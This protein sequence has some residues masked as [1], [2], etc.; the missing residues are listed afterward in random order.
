MKVLSSILFVILLPLVSV[1]HAASLA[2]SS[3]PEGAMAYIISPANGEIVDKSVTIKFGLKGMGVSPAGIDKEGTGHHHLLVDGKMLPAL[4]KPMGTE[5]MHFGGGQTEK[6]LE[7]TAGKHTLQLV[8]GNHNH[9]P[10]NPPIISEKIT[11]IVK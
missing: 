10:H 9:I 1:A 5:V 4:D 8:L 7:L 3:S 6:T 2:I 11:I